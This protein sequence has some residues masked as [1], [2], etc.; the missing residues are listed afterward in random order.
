MTKGTILLYTDTIKTKEVK[1]KQRK[2]N[3]SWQLE[4][5]STIN[6]S[7]V[8]L[9]V[10]QTLLTH[11]NPTSVVLNSSTASPI[12][13]HTDE[14]HLTQHK[15]IE[16]FPI[17]ET[18]D[19]VLAA[20]DTQTLQNK[21]LKLFPKLDTEIL[22]DF[23]HRH[24]QKSNNQEVYITQDQLNEILRSPQYS[25]ADKIITARLLENLS[26][27]S[28]QAIDSWDALP[29]T[30]GV[31]APSLNA[32]SLQDLK[33]FEQRVIETPYDLPI[34]NVL[35]QN[36]RNF[37]HIKLID[38][39]SHTKIDPQVK[40]WGELINPVK[41]LLKSDNFNMFDFKQQWVHGYRDTINQAALLYDIPKLLLG[42][43]AFNEIGGD[44]ERTYDIIIFSLRE[45]GDNLP[46]FITSH[47]SATL[48]NSTATSFGAVSMQIR[49]AA[50]TLGYD[51]AH[52]TSEHTDV[53]IESLWNPR[54][55]IFLAA[56]HLRI[57]TNQDFPGLKASQFS[58][59]HIKITG[60][61]YN[62]GPDVSLKD[63]QKGIQ[64]K[65]SNYTYGLNILKAK[66]LIFKALQ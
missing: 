64:S 25:L 59:N 40:E 51:P 32:I 57:L 16:F 63:I 60:A 55:N 34:Q 13:I 66:S 36:V 21:T 26:F 20:T 29:S 31:Y 45:V 65:D 53:L 56:R 4:I 14:T 6:V 52:L 30:H 19:F 47:I 39:A 43:T 37:Q 17:S 24:F 2:L 61:R 5:Q 42:G 18:V 27:L 50:E 28:V 9:P 48:Q 22:L 46:D 3:I 33:N 35:S 1:L 49:R 8:S 38:Q 58:D 44:P 11:P 10:F 41:Y 7:N 23:A 54:E 15:S 12:L 62:C